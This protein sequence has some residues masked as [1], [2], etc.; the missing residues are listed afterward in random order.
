MHDQC[1]DDVINILSKIVMISWML[2][3][4]SDDV[5]VFYVDFD[6]VFGV[7]HWCGWRCL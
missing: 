1:S 6:D 2:Y 4:S 7:S 3:V 5:M